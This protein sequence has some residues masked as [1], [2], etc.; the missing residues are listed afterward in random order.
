MLS[1][2]SSSIAGKSESMF[3][4]LFKRHDCQQVETSILQQ[5]DPFLETAGED[6]RRRMFT[7]TGPDGEELCLRPDFT[8]PVCLHHLQT[9]TD[10]P[11]RY[12]Y[13]GPVF[14]QRD[15][16][17]GEFLQMGVEHLGRTERPQIED[18][19][20]MAIAVEACSSS[21]QSTELT[22]K[23]GDPSLFYQLLSSL[24]I[25][26]GLKQR[27]IRAFGRGLNAASLEVILKQGD[28]N[29]TPLPSELE[30][31]I[32]N[33]AALTSAV[34]AMMQDQ[35]LSVHSS[36][37]PEAIVERYLDV[38]G[39]QDFG[40]DDTAK[41]KV[42]LVVSEFLQLEGPAL[43]IAARLSDFEME[44]DVAFGEKLD[45][46]T[47]RLVQF[48]KKIGSVPGK[49]EFSSSF[50]RPLD[51]YTGF[52][53]EVFY[54]DAPRPVAGGGRYDRLMEILGAD[55]AVPAVGFSLWLD[56]LPNGSKTA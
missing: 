6:L 24:M 38:Y 7:T 39:P 43:E 33:A 18:G 48:Q 34:A 16:G 35:G 55:T 31:H 47:E 40:I 51:Y 9:K 45:Q 1:D 11:R 5:A 54:R 17:P 15:D 20:V 37:S 23:L 25:P 29:S 26:D 19:D 41:A 8:I 28:A 46:F 32:G 49:F 30:G 42:L 2:S 50:A 13:L 21:S 52:V 27:L 14:R 12:G 10:L 53:F 3:D 36:R 56:R 4:E 22:L 44:H